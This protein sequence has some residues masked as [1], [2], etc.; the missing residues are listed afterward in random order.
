MAWLRETKY[1]ENVI[2]CYMDTN[3]I[4]YRK[5]AVIYGEIAKDVKASVD[6]L[7][8]EL[9]RPLPKRKN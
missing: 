7:N 6:T 2:L 9:D 4:V 1:E 8:Y 5:I 3:F